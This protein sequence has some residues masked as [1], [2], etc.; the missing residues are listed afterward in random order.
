MTSSCALNRCYLCDNP[1]LTCSGRRLIA[2]TSTSTSVHSVQSLLHRCCSIECQDYFLCK[3]CFSKAGKGAKSHTVVDAVWEEVG[4]YLRGRGLLDEGTR[5]LSVKRAQDVT[6]QTD[7][8]HLLD[9]DKS[10]E[11][12]HLL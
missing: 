5:L 1:Q 6:T 9:Y 2:A 10:G 12:M 3:A 7:F 11:G 4:S 8:S